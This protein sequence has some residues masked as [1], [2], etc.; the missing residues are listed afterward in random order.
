MMKKR[1]PVSGE[2]GPE[3]ETPETDEVPEDKSPEEEGPEA[4]Q[5]SDEDT[6]EGI[7]ADEGKPRGTRVRFIGGA[8]IGAV[9][10]G[11]A[12]AYALGVFD[13]APGP[14]PSPSADPSPSVSP[15][16]SPSVPVSYFDDRIAPD[17]YPA[18]ATSR[19]TGYPDALR[20]E[21]WVWDRVGPEWM[22]AMFGPDPQVSSSRAVV[23]LVSPEGVQF[24]LTSLPKSIAQDPTVV[25]WQEDQRTAR[26]QWDYLSEG[27]LLNLADGS[28]DP[29]SFTMKSGASE[30]ERFLSMNSAN[31]EVWMAYG[32]SWLD[33][34]YFTWSESEGWSALFGSNQDVVLRSSSPSNADGSKILLEIAQP[35]DSGL[36]SSRSGKAGRPNLVIYDLNAGKDSFVRPQWPGDSDWCYFDRW[37]DDLSVSYDC[38]ID[39][40]NEYRSYRVFI[41]GN[42]PVQLWDD[43][44]DQRMV[45][46]GV[47]VT[48]EGIPLEFVSEQ[49]ISHIYEIRMVTEDGPVVAASFD[50]YLLRSGHPFGGVRERAPGVFWVWTSDGVVLGIDTVTG[51]VAPYLPAKNSAGEPLVPHSYVFFG[52]GSLPGQQN[53]CW[54]C[55]D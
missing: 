8:V 37:L 38:W 43:L 13:G 17:E 21:E 45:T 55:G 36:A 40:T 32:E 33:V 26:I 34:R 46:E 15:S 35:Y 20:M 31:R 48:L 6:P 25:S 19:G 27:G 18:A 9:I 51:T 4:D 49:G 39:D 1:P 3:D 14:S 5:T 53:H 2:G 47:L 52:E 7:E 29:V 12:G 30:T 16:P 23:Y 50:D 11:G 54:E 28:V 42:K 24:E 22:L 10:L 44:S 41:D